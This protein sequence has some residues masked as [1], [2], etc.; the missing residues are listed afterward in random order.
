[1]TERRETSSIKGASLGCALPL[2]LP[3]PLPSLSLSVFTRS[4]PNHAQPQ[5]KFCGFYPPPLEQLYT[6]L[7]TR[8]GNQ[9]KSRTKNCPKRRGTCS[10]PDAAP[11]GQINIQLLSGSLCGQPSLFLCRRRGAGEKQFSLFSLA[12]IKHISSCKL[13]ASKAAMS[14]NCQIILLLKSLR[15]NCVKKK[16]EEVLLGRLL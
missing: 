10:F 4:L 14:G 2:F 8:K 13:T 9:T 12:K 15:S 6:R 7:A 11:A 1:M 5:R 16:K 3:L